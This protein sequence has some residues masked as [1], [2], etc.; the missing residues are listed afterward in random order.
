MRQA[1]CGLVSTSA[2]ISNQPYLNSLEEIDPEIKNN[3]D[4]IVNL[5]LPNPNGKPSQII[6]IGE[7]GEVTIIRK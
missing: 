7:N 3:V 1:K 4:Y 2:N 5:P 6:K